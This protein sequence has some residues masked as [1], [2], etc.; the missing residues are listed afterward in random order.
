MKKL[1]FYRTLTLYSLA[2]VVPLTL[3]FLNSKAGADR[4]EQAVYSATLPALGWGQRAFLIKEMTSPSARSSLGS[5]GLAYVD[6][7]GI[8]PAVATSTR[9]N[10][11]ARNRKPSSL[12]PDMKL[13][14]QY[15]LISK[16]ELDEICTNTP[17]S[18]DGISGGPINE[19][20]RRYPDT[21]GLTELSRVGFNWDRTEALVYIY[22]YCGSICGYIY[23]VRLEKHGGIWQVK[24]KWLM[25]IS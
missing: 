21:S 2:V 18:P 10:F 13:D 22:H 15:Y 4:D 7:Q 6:M 24:D 16:E 8:T 1:P 12:S 17:P 25:G 14:F 20:S 23:L 3:L 9:N 11:L 5:G 19:M